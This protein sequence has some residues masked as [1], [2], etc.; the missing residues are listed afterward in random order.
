MFLAVVAFLSVAPGRASAASPAVPCTWEVSAKFSGVWQC[1]DQNGNVTELLPDY[2]YQAMLKARQAMAVEAEA[3]N[4]PPDVTAAERE[5]AERALAEVSTETATN[6]DVSGQLESFLAAAGDVPAETTVLGFLGE[7]A[8]PAAGAF[9]V[10]L[11]IGNGIDEI[12]GIGEQA[13]NV[14]EGSGYGSVADGLDFV[15]PGHEIPGDASRPLFAPYGLGAVN[16]KAVKGG[17]N[18]GVRE[19]TDPGACEEETKVTGT[20]GFGLPSNAIEMAGTSEACPSPP[21]PEYGRHIYVVPYAPQFTFGNEGAPETAVSKTLSETGLEP[22]PASEEE[23]A[24]LASETATSPS[25]SSL[26]GFLNA[27]EN[28]GPSGEGV[29]YSE[30]EL[31]AHEEET[32]LRAVPPLG[33]HEPFPTYDAAL[34]SAGLVPDNVELSEAGIDS[35]RG[36]EEV[37]SV[38]PGVGQKVAPGS[39]VKVR[40]NPADAPEPSNPGET[41]EGEPTSSAE[42][43]AP[44]S[45]PSIDLSPIEEVHI[46]CSTFPF[47]VFC[48]Y[49]EALT[50]W[51]SEGTCPKFAVPVGH[52]TGTDPEGELGTNLCELEP[53]ME[54]IRPV[55][56]LLGTLGIGLFFAYAAMGLG[57]PGGED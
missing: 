45:I 24:E 42:G 33:A 3:G 44:P 50:S 5:S 35:R 19:F 37:V 52:A 55:L 56:V 57:S 41:P 20:Q 49:G 14:S 30:A 18:Q 13:E 29:Y 47:G 43:W 23:R 32:A 25:Y 40:Y 51:G 11:A 22:Q 26:N 39:V 54:I 17:A 38:S 12:L 9:G 21:P 6:A 10:G 8:F 16:F 2:K 48:W 36:P 31:E 4:L 7:V 46:G 1:I 15:A 34:E 27:P 53:A 28:G